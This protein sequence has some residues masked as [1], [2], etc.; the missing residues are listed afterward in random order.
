MFDLHTNHLISQKDG[1]VYSNNMIYDLPI[2]EQN[3]QVWDQEILPTSQSEPKVEPE[4]PPTAESLK[5][6]KELIFPLMENEDSLTQTNLLD[7][8]EKE[9]QN[10]IYR[11]RILSY[12]AYREYLAN[13]LLVLNFD[14]K[15]EDRDCSGI[16]LE[17]LRS[18]YNFFLLYP[19][20][21]CPVISLT[22]DN[23]IYASWRDDRNHLFS[24]HFLS[25]GKVHFVIFKPNDKHPEQKIRLSGTATVDTLIGTVQSIGI[26]ELIF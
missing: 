12:L 14:A 1:V 6:S 10:L 3:A 16:A 5:S 18:F 23:N 24:V 25:G 15:E 21:K 22:P 7:R 9:V 20:L 13:R 17:S 26:G 4:Y 2:Y 19:G 11:I 8:E